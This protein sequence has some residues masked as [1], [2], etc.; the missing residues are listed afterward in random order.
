MVATKGH[1]LE[2]QSLLPAVSGLSG[3]AGEPRLNPLPRQAEL[4]FSQLPQ[5]TGRAS[6]RS[7]NGAH[8]H[9]QYLTHGD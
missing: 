6:G 8:W 4:H 5:V 3:T 7:G 1:Q 2:Q 9:Q